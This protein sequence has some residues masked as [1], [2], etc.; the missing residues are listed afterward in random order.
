MG[1]RD[2]SGMNTAHSTFLPACEKKPEILGT[3]FIELQTFQL[4]RDPRASGLNSV[5][6]SFVSLAIS[7]PPEKVS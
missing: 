3:F 7:A 5:L 6:Q 4:G 2:N 1:A